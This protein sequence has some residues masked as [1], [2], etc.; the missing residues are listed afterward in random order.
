MSEWHQMGQTYTKTAR[1]RERNVQSKLAREVL[2]EMRADDRSKKRR[3]GE[4]EDQSNG[5][6]GHRTNEQCFISNEQTKELIELLAEIAFT[7]SSI[8]QTVAVVL[9]AVVVLWSSLLCAQKASG[10]RKTVLKKLST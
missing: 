3:G 4:E 2:M 9:M 5:N 1:H 6:G 10:I 7:D 8:G